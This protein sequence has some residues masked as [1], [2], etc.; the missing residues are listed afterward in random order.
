MSNVIHS[1]VR[2]RLI[3]V[4]NLG[5]VHA[6]TFG[7][8][9]PAATMV[10]VVA[11]IAPELMVE[12]EVDAYIAD[13]PYGDTAVN[14]PFGS[15]RYEVTLITAATGNGPYRCGNTIAAGSLGTPGSHRTGEDNSAGSMRSSTRSVRPAYSRFAGKCTCSGV[16]KCTKP[17]ETSES[18]LS[19]PSTC[20]DRHSWAPQMWTS[21]VGI[22]RIPLA[23]RVGNSV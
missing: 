5:K 16:D 7:D 9:G 11:P 17:F 23:C 1:R 10:A 15:G 21:A 3:A 13:K 14:L 6:E 20:A 2:H 18:G 8:I 22:G 19:W 4:G 12:I